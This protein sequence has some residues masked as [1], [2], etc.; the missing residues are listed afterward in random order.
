MNAQVQVAE[1][2]ESDLS[3]I[4]SVVN[5]V[6]SVSHNLE[7]EERKRFAQRL[8]RIMEPKITEGDATDC[9]RLAWLFLRCDRED[10][11][12]E[13]VE[14]GLKL[15]P[16]NEYCQNLKHKIWRRKAYTARDAANWIEMVEA[17]IRLAELPASRFAE[18]SEA[19]N[20]FNQYSRD[21]EIG[22]DER[23]R[24]ALR[25]SR[26]MEARVQEGD[27]TDCSRLAGS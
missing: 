23:H 12:I 24:M 3:A 9:S 15:D 21:W 8:A 13:I 14:C 2:P 17:S 16:F 18:L 11:A 10:R 25:I 20:V 26:L 7:P 1:L 19:A 5:T 27:A 4:S 6:N 22:D